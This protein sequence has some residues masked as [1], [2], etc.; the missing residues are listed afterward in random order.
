MRANLLLGTPS[1]LGVALFH[2]RT[3][4][5]LPA[6]ADLCAVFSILA[7]EHVAAVELN[8]RGINVLNH[9][10][11]DLCVVVHHRHGVS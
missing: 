7:V 6:N 8:L 10:L 4:V 11:L 1:S 2:H 9:I 3:R 5:V